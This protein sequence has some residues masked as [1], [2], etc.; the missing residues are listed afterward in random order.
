MAAK[1]KNEQ[2]G[3]RW[4][5]RIGLGSG[6]LVGGYIIILAAAFFALRW[7]WTDIPGTIDPHSRDYRVFASTGSATVPLSELH[8]PATQDRGAIEK[9]AAERSAA[10]KLAA[11]I[12]AYPANA[13][14][15]LATHQA[16][17]DIKIVTKMLFAVALRIK[18]QSPL[19]RAWARCDQNPSSAGPATTLDALV[20]PTVPEKA[21]NIF[22]WANTEEWGIIAKAFTKDGESVRL[23][24]THAGADPR[25]IVAT[26]TVEQFRLYFTQ[27]ELFEKFFKPLSILGN[28]TQQAWGVMSIKE[29][30]AID[31]ENHLVDSRSPFYL[32]A[33]KANLLAFSSDKPADERLARL[34]NEKNHYYSFLY[35]GLALAQIACQWKSAGFPIN[36]RPEILATL[37]NIG[38]GHSKPN[39][40]P[41]V[42]GS[43]IDIGGVTYSFGGLA[44]EFYYSGELLDQF[45]YPP[46]SAAPA[47]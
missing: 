16:G 7:H 39:A 41:Q 34:T 12:P 8:L 3:R 36:D 33:S 42:G 43:Q 30:F 37:F 25:M 38:F 2:Q 18:D 19:A 29:K 10:C 17:A 5:I 15:I 22:P 26:G 21:V 11:L 35:G 14:R 20:A 13:A 23:A 1:Q 27:R 31:I 45:V 44:F 9:A 6:I 4:L 24:A 40:D 47:R 32:G 28:A 46:V